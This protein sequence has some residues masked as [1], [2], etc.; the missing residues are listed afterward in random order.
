MKAL[1]SLQ[2]RRNSL[3][4]AD[5]H[6]AQRIPGFC[7]PELIHRGRGETSA[8]GSERMPER[9]RSAIRIHVRSVIGKTEISQNCERLGGERF[10]QLN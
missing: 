10:I 1:H 3:P 2:H 4:Y 7:A 6:G 9:N 5:T 8:T